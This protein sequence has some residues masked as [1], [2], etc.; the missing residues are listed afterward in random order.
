MANTTL[1]PRVILREIYKIMHQRSNFIMRCNR[2]YDDR[3]AQKGAKIGKALDIRLPPKYVTRTGN[4]MQ[5]Q[6]HVERKV[7]LP[8]ATIKGVDLNFTQEELTF[9]LDRFSENVLD[10]AASQ[11]IA[12][13]EADAFNMYKKVPNYVGVVTTTA[14]SGLNYR[15][16]QTTGRYLSENLAPRDQN[17]TACINSESQVEFNDAVKGLFQSS[18]NVREQYVEGLMGRTGGYACFENT[19]VPAHASGIITTTSGAIVVTTSAAAD[20]GVDGTGNAYES[21]P[22]DLKVDGFDSVSLKEGDI[23]TIGGVF[24]VHPETKQSYGY[25]KRFVVASDTDLTTSGTIP[26]LPAPIKSGAYQNVSAAIADGASVT[27][28]GP[29]A[30]DSSIIYGQNLMFHRDAFAFVTADL[31]DPSQYGAWGGREVMDGLS[32][33]IWR[34]GDITNGTFPC[35]LDIAYGY[36]A[37]YPEW[38]CR[39][40]HARQ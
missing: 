37:V 39:H 7:E 23:L 22:F 17:R 26:I 21:D 2:Q 31:E 9:D 19:I 28:H 36:T 15:Q 32:I 5:P 13:V 40:T 30:G 38:G 24:D 33:R 8:L 25:L 29:D 4:A 1:T 20:T 3:F 35:R 10:P 12:D 34:Q 14:G 18:D 16:F 11:L 27:L 6:N